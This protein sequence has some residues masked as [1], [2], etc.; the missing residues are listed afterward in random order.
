MFELSVYDCTQYL[1]P[2]AGTRAV[3]WSE[4]MRFPLPWLVPEPQVQESLLELPPMDQMMDLIEW[5]VQSPLFIYLPVLSKACILNAIVSAVPI[6]DS[7]FEG[8]ERPQSPTVIA[9][10]TSALPQRIAGRVSAVFLLNAIMALGAAYRTNAIKQGTPHKLLSEPMAREKK[11]HDF[12]VFFDRCR[13][14]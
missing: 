9:G 11:Y 12:Q 1:G 7:A 4:E 2:V 6:P 10:E 8:A 13:G 14:K 5:M 3:T